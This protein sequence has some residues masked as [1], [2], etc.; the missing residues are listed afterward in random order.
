MAAGRTDPKGVSMNKS[1][2]RAIVAGHICVDITP[3]FPNQGGKKLGE[4]LVPGRLIN[5]DGVSVSTGGTVANTGLAMKLLGADVKLMGKIGKD[6][7]GELILNHLLK[8]GYDGSEDMICS[9]DSRTSYSV[10]IA[11]PG[12]DRIFLH[13]P[14][15]NNTFCYDDLDFDAIGEGDVFHLGYP[16]LMRRLYENDGEELVRIFQKVKELGLF[17]SLDMTMVDPSS[18][19]GQVPWMR[20]LERVLPYVDLFAPSAEELCYMIDPTRYE[21][22]LSRAGGEDVTG[23]LKW[24]DDIRPLGMKLL[25]MGAGMV[26]IKCGVPGLYFCSADEVRLGETGKSLISDPAAWSRMECFEKSYVPDQIR[27][28]TGCGDTSI[29]AFLTALMEG[30][31]LSTC[32]QFAAGTGAMCVASYDALGGL[33]PLDALRMKIADGWE[34]ISD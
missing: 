14:G 33:I 16:P 13:D 32:L 1:R 31:E 3:V 9:T 27:S 24:E 10:V 11:A 19:A 6:D 34:K 17:T 15:A 21:D 22:W 30:E 12:V 4:I 29:A 28:G 5:M 23:F 7:F 26:L 8:Y 18:E 20:I 2:R 25:K